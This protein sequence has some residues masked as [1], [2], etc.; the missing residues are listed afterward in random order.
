MSHTARTQFDDIDLGAQVI[1]YATQAL[2]FIASMALASA[3]STVVGGILVGIISTVILT[4]LATV[5]AFFITLKMK[6]EHVATIGATTHS[7]MFKLG[8]LFARKAP[9]PIT[10]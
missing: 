1:S 2:G 8:G 5:A 3:C 6:T 10:A 7:V 9:A 4:L